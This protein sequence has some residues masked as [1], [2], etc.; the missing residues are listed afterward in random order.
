MKKVL[1]DTNIIIHREATRILNQDIG[2][3]FK[4]L[5]KGHYSKCVHPITIQ[6]IQKNSNSDAANVILTK[7]DSYEQLKIASP[8]QPDVV[9]VSKRYDKTPNDLN[10]T[11]LLNEVFLN[12]VDFLIT[13]DKKIHQKAEALG[14]QDKVFKI[15]S[16]LNIF[17]TPAY[18]LT[19]RAISRS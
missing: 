1:L 17:F 7:L 8:L 12:R 2:I 19:P 10:D 6:E 15:D 9:D 14:I 13:E 4:W 11:A 5:E 18:L 16:R 3:L